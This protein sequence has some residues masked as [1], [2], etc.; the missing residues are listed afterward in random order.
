MIQK[1]LCCKKVSVDL[2]N[3]G[4]FQQVYRVFPYSFSR[5]MPMSKTVTAPIFLFG[6]YVIIGLSKLKFGP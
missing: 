3:N 5:I 1:L 4:I 6:P 2:Q